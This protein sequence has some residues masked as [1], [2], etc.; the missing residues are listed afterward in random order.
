MGDINC[1]A[2]LILPS[3]QK[4]RSPRRGSKRIFEQAYEAG[5]PDP[6]KKLIKF[7]VHLK[8]RTVPFYSL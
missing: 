2:E 3:A 4:L 6:E 5:P 7:V 1:M 8:N